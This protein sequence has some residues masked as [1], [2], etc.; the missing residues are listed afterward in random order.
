MDREPVKTG[1]GTVLH[2]VALAPDGTHVG[3]AQQ[4]QKTVTLYVLPVAGGAP[5]VL[6]RR[7]WPDTLE[8]LAEWTPDARHLI[9]GVSTE[10]RVDTT[11]LWSVPVNGG[12]PVERLRAPSR[13]MAATPFA[14]I[15]MAGASPS[16]W[17]GEASKSGCLIR[18][19]RVP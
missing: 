7:N 3:Y 5:R 15:R 4:E 14:F 2:S 19:I 1:K 8:N 10:G 12:S 17:D 11:T 9:V 18:V 6:L 16:A 13:G